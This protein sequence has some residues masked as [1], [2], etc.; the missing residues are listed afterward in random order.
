[1]S[2]PVIIQDGTNIHTVN[3]KFPVECGSCH[4]N[5]EPEFLAGAFFKEDNQSLL[6]EAV[7]Q[8]KNAQCNSL[9]I[10]YY[11]R[12]NTIV[13][14]KLD[15]VVPFHL[16]EVLFSPEI[17]QISPQ[18]VK[19]YNQ[20]LRAEHKGL[21]LILGIGFRTA[22]E[23]L[24]KD[25][26]V[27]LEPSNKDRISKRSLYCSLNKID[28]RSVKGISRRAT[29]LSEE[30]VFYSKDWSKKEVD[31]LKKMIDLISTFITMNIKL[32]NQLDKMN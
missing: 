30:E 5:T 4:T 20:L 15:R 18:F 9:I 22:L 13:P 25:Y 1:M 26:L 19:F 29:W 10:G 14:F 28:N 23:I 24:I 12:K 31:D 17:M 21:D 11:R 8:C 6:M 3:I 32:K 16:E 27:H 7:F 2:I